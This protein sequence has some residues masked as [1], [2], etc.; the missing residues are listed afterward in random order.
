MTERDL[1][2]L[3]REHVRLDEPPLGASA[4]AAI[5]AGRRA[6]RRRRLRR[7]AGGILAAAA[8][9]AI[10]VPLLAGPGSPGQQTRDRHLDPATRRALA[11]YDPA[12]MPKIL[13]TAIDPVVRRWSPGMMGGD[14]SAWTDQGRQL[15]KGSWRRASPRPL[16]PPRARR[17]WRPTPRCARACRRP[18]S[19]RGSATVASR[20][21]IVDC[22]GRELR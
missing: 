14:F 18:S 15:P 4:D 12:A 9:A 13:S 22:G 8:V 16:R 1:S 10:T 11:D 5:L 3:L 21:V 2:T 20:R 6:L 19:W 7:G 17:C